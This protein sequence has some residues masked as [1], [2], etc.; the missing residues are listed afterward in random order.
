MNIVDR[1]SNTKGKT[2][3]NT[4]NKQDKQKNN[5]YAFITGIPVNMTVLGKP[6]VMAEINFLCAH[7]K[8][9][10]LR[11]APVLI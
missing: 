11:L 5:L 9:R 8:L 4:H 3:Y 2:R 10:D 1:K 7:K 6:I